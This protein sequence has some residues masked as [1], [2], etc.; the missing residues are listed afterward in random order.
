MKALAL[1]AQG[2]RRLALI[3]VL[4]TAVAMLLT[5]Q[6]LRAAEHTTPTASAPSAGEVQPAP[7]HTDSAAGG[8][9]EKPE[10]FAA[11]LVEF[12]A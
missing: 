1:R 5:P 6:V 4:A 12:F 11:K 7:A 2:P 8:H 10:L 9:E 3:C